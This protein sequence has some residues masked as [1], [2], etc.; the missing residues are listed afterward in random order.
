LQQSRQSRR[1]D[2]ERENFEKFDRLVKENGKKKKKTRVRSISLAFFGKKDEKNS[3]QES[4][5]GVNVVVG[6]E[7]RDS[8]QETF[9]RDTG[10]Q[11]VASECAA[12]V[13][14]KDSVCGDRERRKEAKVGQLCRR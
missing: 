5:D 9:D 11:K 7:C 6:S 14:A 4:V 13:S 2:E 3:E 10:G 8:K 1:L 12:S